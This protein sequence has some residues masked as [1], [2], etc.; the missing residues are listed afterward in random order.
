MSIKEFFNNSFVKSIFSYTFIILIVILI[1]IFIFDPVRVDG[2]SMDTTLQDG[3]IMI[4]NKIYYKKNDIKRF[5]IVVVDA[6][7]KNIIK[8]VIGLP[9]EKVNYQDNKLYING[10]RVKDK[11]PSTETEDF[12]LEDIGFEKIPGNGYVVMGDNRS[13]SLDSRSSSIGIVKK[14]QIIGRAKFIIYPF[15]KFGKV[16]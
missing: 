7:D 14:S 16:E 9:G 4:L 15:K 3:E 10:K 13:N 1:R 5:D 8:R 12:K 2:H 11:Y 6:G